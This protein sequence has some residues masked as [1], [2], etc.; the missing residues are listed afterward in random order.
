MKQSQFMMEQQITQIEQKNVYEQDLFPYWSILAAF[1]LS[2]YYKNLLSQGRKM[3]Q[4]LRL[5][6]AMKRLIL[7]ILKIKLQDLMTQDL[8]WLKER[9]GS[10]IQEKKKMELSTV[11]DDSE[12][13]KGKRSGFHLK[14]LV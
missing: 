14:E 8:V 5:E 9:K 7:V 3:K 4:V 13:A 2:I 1:Q 11:I 10:R 6:I 12:K